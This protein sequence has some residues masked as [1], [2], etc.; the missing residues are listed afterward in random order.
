MILL[1]IIRVQRTKHSVER[2]QC[3]NNATVVKKPL[4]SNNVQLNNVQ[5]LIRDVV[6]QTSKCCS[7]TQCQ[8]SWGSPS[9]TVKC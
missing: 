3:E 6:W 2:R 4:W 5:L 1:K 8:Q 7:V 9:N